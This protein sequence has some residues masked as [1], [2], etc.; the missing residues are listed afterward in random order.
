MI[1]NIDN[2]VPSK[3]W[4]NSAEILVEFTTNKKKIDHNVA[5]KHIIKTQ[6]MLKIGMLHV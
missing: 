3:Y 6:Y 4:E 2:L 1:E 5:Y